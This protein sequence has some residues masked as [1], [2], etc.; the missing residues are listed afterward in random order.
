MQLITG[1]FIQEC[2]DVYIG[3]REYFD[4]NPYIAAHRDKHLLINDLFVASVYNNPRIVFCYSSHIW[5]LSMNIHKFV[6]PFILITHNGDINIE[7]VYYINVI[8]STPNLTKW[9]AQNV[10]YVHSKLVPLPIG[11]ANRMWAHGQFS[12]ID[13]AKT[14]DVYMFFDVN[15]NPTARLD[16]LDALRDKIPFLQ[17][18]APAVNNLRLS[19]YKYCICPIGNG[20]DTHRLWEALYLRVVPILIRNKHIE[21]L[22]AEYQ[23]PAILVDSWRDL[24]VHRLPAYESFTWDTCC[25]DFCHLRDRIIM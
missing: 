15:T 19:S 18:V 4:S 13:S 3:I 22:M 24:D 2:A 10:N 23:F 16:C 6:N 5:Q 8:L 17:F 9:Y 21:L 20:L 12:I 7:D 25:L 14:C 1:D 11:V